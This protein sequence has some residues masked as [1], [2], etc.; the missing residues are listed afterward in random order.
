MGVVMQ[1][2]QL[3][4]G[5]LYDN[6]VG[7]SGGSLDDA[8]AAARQVGLAADIEAM[9][10]GMQTLVLEGGGS[11]SGGQMQ[12]MMIARAIVSRPKILLLDE[13]TSALDNRS[14]AVVTDSL[15]RLRVTR[16]VVAHRLS[17]VVN[18]DRIY[19]LD[20]GRLIETGTYNEL[21]QAQGHFAQLAARQLTE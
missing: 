10:M 5:S 18:A 16:V 17:T 15:D 9:P 12:R 13:A 7:T 4:P 3:M 6:I 11:L 21:M 1:Q 2:S 14:Q 8:W 20:A 19:V